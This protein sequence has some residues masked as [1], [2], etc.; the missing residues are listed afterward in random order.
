MGDLLGCSAGILSWMLFTLAGWASLCGV[1]AHVLLIISTSTDNWI[2]FGNESIRGLWRTCAT[3]EC[4]IL[5]GAI[6][7]KDSA[8]VYIDV[9]RAFMLLSV[10]GCLAGV[11]LGISAR[12]QV[13][14]IRMRIGGIALLLAGFLAFLALVTYTV[15]SFIENQNDKKSDWKFGWSYILGWIG[16]ISA[17]AAGVL[18]LCANKHSD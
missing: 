2:A 4:K 1:A 3:G 7:S 5:S 6:A 12:K 11:V 16:T 18:Q 17:L 10:L 13:Q 9:T 8:H 15:M 14:S